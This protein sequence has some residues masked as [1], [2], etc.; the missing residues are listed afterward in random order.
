[1]VGLAA[2]ALIG[3]IIGIVG[4]F[5]VSPLVRRRW[6]AW[7]SGDVTAVHEWVERDMELQIE[8]AV[9]GM[10][11]GAILGFAVFEVLILLHRLR[12]AS[13]KEDMHSQRL[14]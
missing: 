12:T 2:L 1:M 13:R 8:C 4:G 3:S 6:N 9:G 14:R 11:L 5:C 10:I 7:E